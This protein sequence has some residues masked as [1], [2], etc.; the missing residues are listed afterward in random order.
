MT[1]L[2]P[3]PIGPV[4]VDEHRDVGPLAIYTTSPPSARTNPSSYPRRVAEVARWTEAAGC[5]GLL[6]YTDNTLIDPW[7]STQVIIGHTDRVIPLVAVQPVYLHPYAAA[8]MVASI[9]YLSSRSLHLNLVTG[10]SAAH[11][12][13]LGDEEPHDGRYDRLLEYAEVVQQLLS[14][15]RPVSYRGR[16]F[17]LRRATLAHR[18]PPELVPRL[19]VSGSSP[20]AVR[21][22]KVLG[23]PRLAYPRPPQDYRDGDATMHGSGIRIGV[24]AREYG[25]AAWKVARA[26]FPHD[27]DGERVH[28][29]VARLSDSHWHAELSD[30]R[31][32]GGHARDGYWTYPFL[33]YK[34]FCPYLVGSY[35]DVA[36][37]LARYLALGVR[38]V[39]LDVPEEDDDLQ[40]TAIAFER[41][42]KV[43]R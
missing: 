12:A 38:T 37:H 15:Q 16:Y 29:V 14:D 36:E 32:P 23:V 9:G 13:A 7:L 17:Q 19:F 20:A 27:A 30:L 8:Q 35:D 10:G 11:L 41:A 21:A 43:R 4:Q 25:P 31:P 40:H 26:R 1:D 34:T 42:E 39:V 5:T 33:T 2:S 6:V 22:A 3:R 18:I 28:S 24:I